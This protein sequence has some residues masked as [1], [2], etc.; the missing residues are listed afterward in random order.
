MFV[1]LGPGHG[2]KRGGG[3]SVKQ[4]KESARRDR[5]KNLV[6]CRVFIQT[7]ILFHFRNR[8]IERY[9]F[10]YYICLVA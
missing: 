10:E 9:F 4:T 2:G 5:R 1:F 7:L 8:E 3:G 6:A